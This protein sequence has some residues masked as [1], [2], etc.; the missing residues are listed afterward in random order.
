[1]DADGRNTLTVASVKATGG[2]SITESNASL[3]WSPDGS[4]IAF[5]HQEGEGVTRIYVVGREGEGLQ[6]ITSA[7]DGED[8]SLSWVL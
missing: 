1:M 3:V 4:K 6:Q 7:P 5:T 2:G 8:V